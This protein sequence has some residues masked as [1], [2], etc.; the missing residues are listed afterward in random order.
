V[1]RQIRDEEEFGPT[2]DWYAVDECGATGHFTTAGFRKLPAAIEGDF[3][4]AE[5]CIRYFDEA[6][7]RSE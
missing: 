4:A 2:W 6:P 5:N 1:A 7:V 3:E